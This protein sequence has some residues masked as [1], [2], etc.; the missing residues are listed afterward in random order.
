MGQP[1]T[2]AGR[3]VVLTAFGVLGAGVL[4]QAGSG[5]SDAAVLIGLHR[6]NEMAIEAGQLAVQR[7]QEDAVRRYGELIA[8]DQHRADTM[9]LL[10]LARRGVPIGAASASGPAQVPAAS[11]RHATIERLQELHG[12]A[13]D[14]EFVRA[15]VEVQGPSMEAAVVEAR[16]THDAEARRLLRTIAPILE[17]HLEIARRLMPTFRSNQQ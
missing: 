1:R 10:L 15:M 11:M 13:F 5:A 4:A 16:R 8:R 14:R 2:W 17:Q 9:L 7:G 6:A 12:R 3:G